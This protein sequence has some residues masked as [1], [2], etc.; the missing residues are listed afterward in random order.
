MGYDIDIILQP[1]KI[2]HMASHG[3]VCDGQNYQEKLAHCFGHLT[4]VTLIFK[5]FFQ[6]IFFLYDLDI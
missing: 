6:I 5:C 2:K 1:V 4:L 3:Q